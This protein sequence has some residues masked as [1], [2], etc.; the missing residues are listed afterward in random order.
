M[1]KKKA[2]A[3]VCILAVIAFGVLAW[4]YG[5]HNQKSNE[6]LQDDYITSTFSIDFGHSRTMG[7]KGIL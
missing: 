5:Y 3:A 2:T 4:L 1:L 6:H 7:R